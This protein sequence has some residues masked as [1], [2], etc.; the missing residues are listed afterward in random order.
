[1]SWVDREARKVDPDQDWITLE[2][3]DAVREL[4]GLMRDTF[5]PFLLGE[6]EKTCF[7]HEPAG[8]DAVLESDWTGTSLRR[9]LPFLLVDPLGFP[10]FSGGL[11]CSR[12]GF[13]IEREFSIGLP[14]HTDP[15]LVFRIMADQ[16]FIGY[17]PTMTI[18]PDGGPTDRDCH[19]CIELH[20][21]EGIETG[22]WTLHNVAKERLQALIEDVMAMYD[23]S[24]VQGLDTMEDVEEFLRIAERSFQAE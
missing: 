18:Q 5:L 12:T 2:N 24:M 6:L 1:M 22:L 19:Y 10:F 3:P 9:K 17:L 20:A 11:S 15:S 16:R 4:D 21:G 7:Q 23:R 8:M 13:M 14:K